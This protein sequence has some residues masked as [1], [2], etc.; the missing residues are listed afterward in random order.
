[1]YM[2]N[3]FNSIVKMLPKYSYPFLFPELSLNPV[4]TPSCSTILWERIL[5]KCSNNT[6]IIQLSENYPT[7]FHKFTI[8]VLNF[9]L[10]LV[11]S[12]LENVMN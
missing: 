4:Y 6:N 7:S 12:S 5:K 2:T 11:M 1:M 8:S 10:I 3:H 9:T